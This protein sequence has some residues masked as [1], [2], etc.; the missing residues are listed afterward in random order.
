[1]ICTLAVSVCVC[2][3]YFKCI[4]KQVNDH[5][6]AEQC[7]KKSLKENKMRKNCA[8]KYQRIKMC[9]Y[10]MS[11]YVFIKGQRSLAISYTFL[12]DSSD[13]KTMRQLLIKLLKSLLYLFFILFQFFFLLVCF[14][15]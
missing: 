3:R 13:I 8:S 7:T 10:L 11:Q 5:N 1:M 12:W 6:T 14:I 4:P 2:F 9:S 15:L